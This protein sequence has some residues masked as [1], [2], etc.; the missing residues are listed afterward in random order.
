M[1]LV[2]GGVLTIQE[3][4]MQRLGTDERVFVRGKRLI[5]PRVHLVGRGILREDQAV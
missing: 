5:W 2:R 1:H 3:I 4:V